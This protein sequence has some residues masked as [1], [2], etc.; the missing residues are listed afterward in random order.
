MLATKALGYDSGPMDGLDF[1]AVAQLI[2]LPEDHAI[3]MF[4]AIG[5]GTKAAW[6]RVGKL[7]IDEVVIIDRSRAFRP[8]IDS[9]S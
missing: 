5:K 8:G 7:S 2:R 6:L 4:V 9:L 3:S 1:D